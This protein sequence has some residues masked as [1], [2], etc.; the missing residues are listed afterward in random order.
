MA[1]I[2]NTFLWAL[3]PHCSAIFFA[4]I[5]P[6]LRHGEDE[7]QELKERVKRDHGLAFRKASMEGCQQ[8]WHLEKNARC[9]N[10]TP[11][12]VTSKCI[13]SGWT[14]V[15]CD[16]NYPKMIEDATE[17]ELLLTSVSNRKGAPTYGGSVF[18]NPMNTSPCVF[19][20]YFRGY[21]Y[22]SC[23]TNGS[24]WLWCYTNIISQTWSY[25]H[26]PLV[27]DFDRSA[28]PVQEQVP[29]VEKKTE[30]AGLETEEAGRGEETRE[31]TE[32][33]ET[34]QN[35]PEGIF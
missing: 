11:S 7:N 3:V 25:C 18:R 24:Q 16:A 27:V 19:P 34:E 30:E 17:Q 33:E 32:G 22:Y 6:W 35:G 23:A 10:G 13:P 5:E 26:T 20:F 4:I 9:D 14:N 8:E 15:C 21:L 29:D 1:I 28:D 31:N 2:R 12:L